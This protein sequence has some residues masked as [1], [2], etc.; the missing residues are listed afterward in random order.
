MRL[1]LTRSTRRLRFP[2]ALS[3]HARSKTRVLLAAATAITAAAAML[4]AG[5]P[6]YAGGLDK[7]LC[8][9]NNSRVTIPA[10]LPVN[11]CF[12]GHNL[13]IENPLSFPIEVHTNNGGTPVVAPMANAS[14]PGAILSMMEPA[15]DGLTP[16]NYKLTIPIT[17][18]QTAVTIIAAPSNVA[19]D[20]VWGQELYD[21]LGYNNVVK[22][23]MALASLVGELTT[24]TQNYRTCL[25]AAT[26]WV[27]RVGCMAGYDGN[28]AYA[29]GRF[30]IKALTPGVIEATYNLVMTAINASQ[31]ADQVSAWRN[32][33]KTFTIAAA[34]GTTAQGSSAGTSS[35]ASPS[36][37]ASSSNGQLIVQLANFPLGTT[38]YFCHSGS[39]YPTGGT[40]ASKGSVSITSHNQNLGALCS[41]SGNFWIGFQATDGH[42]YYSNQVTLGG[43]QASPAPYHAGKQVSIVSQATGGVTGHAG[44]GNQYQVGPTNYAK[45]SPIWIV[46]HVNGQSI[47]GP[48]GTEAIW[49][50]SDDGWYYSDAWIYTGTNG[51]AVPPC[52]LKTVTI[53]SQAT[54]GVT[55]H[56]GPGNQYAA[57]PNHAKGTS[58]QIA[59][60]VTGQS[61]TGPYDT[62]TIWDLAVGGYWYTDAWLYTGTNEAAVPH[63]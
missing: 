50:L 47:A 32:G 19:S 48:Y 55:G 2:A 30:G 18:Q 53:F 61:I 34:S 4:I 17:G 44:P 59:C 31:G 11:A 29:L 23:G 12:D 16:P 49:D 25:I 45:S 41:G 10:S 36:A 24:V 37:T 40:I 5:Q 21:A 22:V 54:G 58:I 9:P 13:V 33:A 52:S 56:T 57:G 7:A 27:G 28:V 62:T 26:S 14:L 60:Y 46:C 20:Y 43:T 6:A 39:G 38:Y 8:S 3:R 15:I 42:D 63:C 51:P 1:P 35:P